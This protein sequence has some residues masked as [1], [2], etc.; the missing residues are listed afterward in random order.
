MYT[1]GHAL[2]AQLSGCEKKSSG[3]RN[4]INPRTTDN[5]SISS[6]AYVLVADSG[7]ETIFYYLSHCKV[8]HL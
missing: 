4:H 3:S 5:R 6:N 8:V 2:Y 1:I 7:H